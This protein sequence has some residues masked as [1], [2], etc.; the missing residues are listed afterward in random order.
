MNEIRNVPGDT[1]SQDEMRPVCPISGADRSEPYCSQTDDAG[2]TWDWIR[3][4][5]SGYVRLKSMPVEDEIVGLQDQFSGG[6]IPQLT[7]KWSSKARR[8]K[9]RARWLKGQMQGGKRLLDVGSNIGLFCA[10]A[11]EIGLEP[12][13]IEITE[14]L[15]TKAAEL[16]PD[17]TF[18]CTSLESFSGAGEFDGI[19]CSEVI[20]HTIDP[21]HF[22]QCL[23]DL[24]RPGGVLYLTTP[25]L[26]EYVDGDGNPNRDLGAPDHKLYFSRNNIDAFLHNVGFS[27]IQ[28]KFSFGKG[29]Q[30][31]ATR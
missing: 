3:F 13:G 5:V 19:Y 31:L 18:H 1:L 30:L 28:H 6:Y 26:L 25:D 12:T 10:K 7:S 15:A 29:I 4:P 2:M 20:E 9:R 8:S 24:L 14:E 17:I 21:L 23:F 27:K 11:K 16:F 22:A